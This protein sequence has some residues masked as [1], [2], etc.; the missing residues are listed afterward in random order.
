M[1]TFFSPMLIALFFVLTTLSCN[2][3]EIF[4][5]EP[6]NGVVDPDTTVDTNAPSEDT[7]DS[8]VDTTLP[9]SFGLDSV[10]SGDTIVINCMLDL[11]GQ[12]VN[13]PSNVTIVY[14]G[15]DI[16]NGT[17]HFSDNTIISGELLNS[18]VTL[19]GST[20]QLK[21]T[22]FQFDPQRWGIVEGVVSDE[23]ALK[24]KEILN[25]IIQN[26]KKLGISVFVIDKMDAYFKVD[27]NNNSR[28]KNAANA[29]QIPS[30]FEL[31]MNDDTFLRVQPN[32][33]AFYTLM[34]IFLTDNSIV[35]GGHLVGDRFE[36]N[37]APVIDEAGEIRDTHEYGHLLWIIGSHNVV[38]DNLNLSKATGDAILFHAKTLR[39]PDGALG[40]GNREVN[41][42]IVENC[43]I[44]ECRRNGISFLDGRNVTIDN[45]RIIDTG[46]GEQAY[47]GSGNKIAS[48]AGTAP[49]YG[50]DLE[51]IRT[52]NAD[53]S[54]NETAII[55]NIT[56]KNSTLTGNESGDIVLFTANDVVIENNYFDKW[57]SNFASYNVAILNNTFE[58]RDPSIFAIGI[59]SYFDP[60][61]EE[62][63]HHYQISNNTIKN[64]GVGIRVA[65]KNQSISNNIIKDC[66]TGIFLISN[67]FDSSFSGNTIT[68]NLEVSFGYKNFYNTQSINNVTISNE[69]I[70][71]KNRP[72]SLIHLLDES[73]L[74]TSQITFKSCN[75]NTTNIGFKL[76]VDY[77]KNIKFDGNTSNTDFEIK[78]SENIGLTNNII[79]N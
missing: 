40:S 43:T 47:D 46:K 60:F 23:V 59:Q 75:F 38:V 49:R 2:N 28:E 24:N 34:S 27:L 53:G 32:G 4:S 21:D 54:L 73:T 52:R 57:V 26:T 51:A 19:M 36:H 39:N 1:K 7:N 42:A 74:S 66:T 17:L 70:N 67:L 78:N 77:G 69:T 14:E 76:H 50:I 65:G 68:S 22:T 48:S 33:S 10:Q 29:I 25:N 8:T 15:G 20:P 79:G 16:I 35:S 13:L 37:Y 44:S 30:D 9:C 71:V 41:Y 61:G 64:Y 5:E 12:T 11:G 63:N 18:S 3:E 55:E 45:C 31:K 72:L 56:I 58:S 62:L 6:V